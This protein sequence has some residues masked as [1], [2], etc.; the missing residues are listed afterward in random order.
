MV[1]L[2]RNIGPRVKQL[3]SGRASDECIE[4]SPLLLSRP[5]FLLL[6]LSLSSGFSSLFPAS[7]SA[8]ASCST[9]VTTTRVL[10]CAPSLIACCNPLVCP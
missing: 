2:E 6:F 1:V 4:V 8:S 10:Q 7:A 9:P 3:K 5:F